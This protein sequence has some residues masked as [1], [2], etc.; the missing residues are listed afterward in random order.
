MTEISRI[1]GLDVGSKTIGVA[2]SDLMGWTAQGVEVIR[3]RD[4]AADLRR[5]IELIAQYEVATIVIGLPKNM[6][7]TIGPQAE[8]VL[9]FKDVLA[10]QVPCAIVMWDERLTTAS[11][12]RSM[13]EADLSRAKRK[14]VV[15]KVAATFILQG[16]LDRLRIQRQRE[17]EA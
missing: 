9:S 10:Q 7:N 12:H 8:A 16:Y 17:E 14:Q 11:A 3:R 5:L 2:V 1:M 15:D 13:L 6:N 4:L